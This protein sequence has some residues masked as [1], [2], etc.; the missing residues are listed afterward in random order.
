MQT[1]LPRQP[2]VS[3]ESQVAPDLWDPHGVPGRPGRPKQLGRPHTLSPTAFPLRTSRSVGSACRVGSIVRNL[4]RIARGSDSEENQCF[5]LKS[6]P[7]NRLHQ[8]SWE[9]EPRPTKS[10]GNCGRLTLP[11]SGRPGGSTCYNAPKFGRYQPKSGRHHH[12]TRLTPP[13][14]PFNPKPKSLKLG[15]FD[16]NRPN[17][18]LNCPQRSH[19]QSNRPA[20]CQTQP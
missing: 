3:R 2:Q 13:E 12:Q 8:V 7:G 17:T 10:E 20:F 5:R 4:S 11:I 18:P 14:L 19:I 6:R 1:I 16:P 9:C 15:R